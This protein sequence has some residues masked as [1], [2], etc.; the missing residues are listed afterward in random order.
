[1]DA[2]TKVQIT[3]LLY[4]LVLPVGAAAAVLFAGRKL[5]PDAVRVRTGLAVTVGLAVAALGING[6][7]GS[8]LHAADWLLIGPAIGG[9]LLT[10]F[11]AFGG[12][13]GRL[14]PWVGGALATALVGIFGWQIAA[15]LASAWTDGY[16]GPLAGHLWVVDGIALAAVVWIIS[17]RS[18]TAGDADGVDPTP[19]VLGSLALALVGAALSIGL[20]GSALIGQMVGGFAAVVGLVGLAGW[21]WP[22][23]AGVGHGAA[24]VALLALTLALLQGHLFVDM[25]RPVAVLLLLAP[26]GGIAGL[27]VG[28]SLG[29][30]LPAV[31]VALAL[32]GALVGGAVGL[33]GLNEQV[34]AEAAEA[35]SGGD[36][37]TYLPY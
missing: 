15:A 21:R 24:G 14:A 20:S 16:A 3:G 30:T 12:G 31:G 4:T 28:R 7:P 9:L 17:Q 23:L 33:T 32:T 19:A 27:A 35:D 2:A 37:G 6:A 29:R 22:E 18:L 5:R 8:P 34:K 26:L 1:M 25:P 36:D 11:D 13:L 10:A